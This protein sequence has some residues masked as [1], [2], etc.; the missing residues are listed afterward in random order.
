MRWIGSSDAYKA[1]ITRREASKVNWDAMLADCV[2]RAEA[3]KT[4]GGRPLRIKARL[5]SLRVEYRSLLRSRHYV[6][7]GVNVMH[8]ASA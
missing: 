6:R 5:E 8:H 7:T 4:Q 3:V 2:A 1:A